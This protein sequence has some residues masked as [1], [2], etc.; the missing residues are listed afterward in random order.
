MIGE[1]MTQSSACHTSAEDL[2]LI[3]RSHI[4]FQVWGTG[5]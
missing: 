3:Y 1:E 4:L 2:S 5:L